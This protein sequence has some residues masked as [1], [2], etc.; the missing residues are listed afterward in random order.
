MGCRTILGCACCARAHPSY[1]FL[2]DIATSSAS[3]YCK[4]KWVSE[5]ECVSEWGVMH[6]DLH[7]M[8]NWS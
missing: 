3:A 1:C 2:L 5:T 4:L 8:V 7:I 6:K